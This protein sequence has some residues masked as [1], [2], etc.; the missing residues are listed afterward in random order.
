[1]IVSLSLCFAQ[2]QVEE[3]QNLSLAVMQ[4][5]TGF[6]SAM[7]EGVDLVV[8]PSPNE[9]VSRLAS[10]ELD[11]ACLPANTAMNLYS[12]GVKIKA[13]AVVGEGMLSLV[14]SGS[15]PEDKT[16]YVPGAGGTPDH[17]AMLF[18]KD[19]TIERSVAAPAQLAQMI[20]AKKASYALLPEPFVTMI[21]NSSKDA[22]IVRDMNDDWKALTGQSTYPMSILVASEKAL[23]SR[24]VSVLDAAAS[25]K[26]SV[27]K[28]LRD[29]AQAGKRIEE[30]G[31]M[32]A[33]L[34]QAAIPN[35]R[36]VYVGASQAK[37][38]IMSYCDVLL[39]L[40]PQAIGSKR[41]DDGFFY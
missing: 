37:E 26:A 28:V 31:I 2:G 35:C 30:L 3:S 23:Q 9:V 36:L 41:I 5:P 10:G 13:L 25:Y 12:K 33:A 38:Q 32:K 39:E 19:Y 27:E 17:F 16:V 24:P 4:G 18:C 34:A 11:M 40:A 20:I 15:S 22:Y 29:P 6:S 7:I 1:M 21:L 8:Y 14:C